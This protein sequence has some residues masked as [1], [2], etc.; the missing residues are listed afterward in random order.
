MLSDVKALNKLVDPVRSAA[1]MGA[2][3]P[4]GVVNLKTCSVICYT[5]ACFPKC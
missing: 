4:S 2:V 5:E 1:E 3:I